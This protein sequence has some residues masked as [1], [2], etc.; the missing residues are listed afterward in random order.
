MAPKTFVVAEAG[1]AHEGDWKTAREMIHMAKGA[2]ADAFKVQYWSNAAHLADRRRAKAFLA[3]YEKYALPVTWLGPLAQECRQAGIAFMCTVY[4]PEDIKVVDP[5]VH[6]F[7]VASFEALDFPF[8]DQHPADGRAVMVSLGMVGNQDMDRL[9]ERRRGRTSLKYLHCVSGY[10]TPLHE[11]N[12]SVIRRYDLDGFSDHTGDVHM[13]ADAVLAGA[14]IVEVH[15]RAGQTSPKNPDYPHSLTPYDLHRY[16]TN[17]RA[18][19]VRLGDP[20]K[21]VQPSERE[22]L[23]YQV[24]SS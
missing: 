15:F 24:F 17:I 23:N 16:V 5:F 13:G 1:S 9:L 18:A 14:R 3:L 11:V 7:K 4:L 21:C 2:G 8:V 6:H 20:V 22:N 19:E 10:P 12:L